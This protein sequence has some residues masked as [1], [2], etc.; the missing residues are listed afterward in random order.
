MIY[1]STISTILKY[2][3]TSL[4]ITNHNLQFLTVGNQFRSSRIIYQHDK[5]PSTISIITDHGLMVVDH[6]IPGFSQRDPTT[7]TMISCAMW[8][9]G[10][11]D[12]RHAELMDLQLWVSWM[13]DGGLGNH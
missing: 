6:Q 3:P 7:N 9:Q 5:A 1:H 13:G 11:M 10:E 8:G 12:L 2:H 4:L